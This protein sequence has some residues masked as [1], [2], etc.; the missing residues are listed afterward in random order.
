MYC[1]CHNYYYSF[2]FVCT[3]QVSGLWLLYKS[4]TLGEG[5]LS[6]TLKSFTVIDDRE[7][8]EQELRLAVRK[9]RTIGYT[10]S[11][12]LTED[13]SSIVENNVFDDCNLELVPTMLL[14]DA[15]FSQYSTS[16][17]VCMQRPQLLVALDFLLAVVEFFVP[18]VRSMVSSEE[19]E[20][21]SHFIDA[22]V[23]DKP[24]YT[25]PDIEFSLSSKIPLVVDDERYNHFIYDGKGGTLYLQDRRGLN[26]SSSS[27]ECM[28]FIGSGKKL[29]F[30]NV[31]IKV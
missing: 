3:C 14:L 26:V 20:S 31:Y 22:I 8:I 9:S 19:D 27:A 16:V 30:K 18:A 11:E 13:D 4:N 29:Q 1:Y 24:T 17:S 5:F 2:I 10:M 6:S 25:Q 23:I 7:G 15:K 21:S 12:H 28:I